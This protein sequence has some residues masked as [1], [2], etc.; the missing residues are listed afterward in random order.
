MTAGPIPP[1]TPT[2][3]R[4]LS[5]TT[6]TRQKRRRT[7]RMKVFTA[8]TSKLFGAGDPCL[9]MSQA[10]AVVPRPYK[11][12]TGWSWLGNNWYKAMSHDQQVCAGHF[13]IERVIHC[14]F[15][16]LSFS[17]LG[18]H[19]NPP[20]NR[21]YGNTGPAV[22]PNYST[23]NQGRTAL[24]PRHPIYLFQ[25]PRFSNRTA[26]SLETT[27]A[28]LKE[29]KIKVRSP[30]ARHTIVSIVFIYFIPAPGIHYNLPLNRPY[31]NAGSVV[32]PNRGTS[33][34]G[35]A[36]FRSRHPIYLF[37][38]PR[39]SNRTASSLET[40]PA[41]LKEAKIKVR[42]SCARRTMYLLYLFVLF[43]RWGF[44]TTSP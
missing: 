15:E 26:S 33:S 44:T 41:P 6:N 23:S 11:S 25:Q 21:P 4:A 24:R 30:C 42:S 37:Q 27:L 16:E 2:A 1:R 34:Q 32:L 35:R 10:S 13:F 14:S 5:L 22:L 40:T 28:P 31:G 3:T 9:K 43:Q 12:S 29:A 20:L 8:H 7:R 39:F 18:I 19:H 17:A 38:Q 36:I